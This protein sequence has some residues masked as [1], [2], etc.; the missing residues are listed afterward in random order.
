MPKQ[1]SL[2]SLSN[3]SIRDLCSKPSITSHC[4]WYDRY[5]HRQKCHAESYK[6]FC[7]L[8]RAQ[9]KPEPENKKCRTQRWSAHCE[10]F[11][12]KGKLHT[13]LRSWMPKEL[14]Y[15]GGCDKFTKRKKSHNGKCKY[16]PT[17]VYLE[18]P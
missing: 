3:S 4:S 7:E 8:Q 12:K 10:C 13:Q 1:D 16:C 11:T 6:A 5:S 15:C 17:E 14:L 2:V 9:G 18:Q